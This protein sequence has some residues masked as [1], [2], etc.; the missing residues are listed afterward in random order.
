MGLLLRQVHCW[1]RFH[2]SAADIFSDCWDDFIVVSGSLLGLL[3]LLCRGH[4]CCSFIVGRVHC[5]MGFIVEV[6]FLNGPG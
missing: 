3:L 2:F 5:F 6:G 1:C 4:Y